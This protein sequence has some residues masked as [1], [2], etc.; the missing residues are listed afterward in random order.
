MALSCTRIGSSWI[1][2]KDGSQKGVMH[3]NRLPREVVESPSPEMFKKYSKVALRD[4]ISGHEGDGFMAGLGAIRGL[5]L[6]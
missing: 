1:L 2:G 3:W 6:P 5:F 4:M